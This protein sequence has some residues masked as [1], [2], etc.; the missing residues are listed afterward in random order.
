MDYE[1]HRGPLKIGDLIVIEIFGKIVPRRPDDPSPQWFVVTE[2]Q[3]GNEAVGL[4][5]FHGKTS[6]HFARKY[7]AS[8]GH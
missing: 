6:K 7:V 8:W 3:R 5:P 4:M 1:L 2:D